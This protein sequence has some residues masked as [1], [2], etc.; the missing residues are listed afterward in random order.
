MR[1]Y[2]LIDWAGPD[3]DVRHSDHIDIGLLADLLGCNADVATI[4]L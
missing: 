3:P 2:D 4:M 1:K